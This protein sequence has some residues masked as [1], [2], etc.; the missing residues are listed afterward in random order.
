MVCE[1]TNTQLVEVKPRDDFLAIQG[2]FTCNK[3]MT[4]HYSN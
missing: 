4:C 1:E 2:N 3:V